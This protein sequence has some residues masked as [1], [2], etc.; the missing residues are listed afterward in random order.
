MR[1]TKAKIEKTVAEAA[2]LIELRQF[3]KALKLLAECTEVDP[4]CAMAHYLTG[5]ALLG[6]RRSKDA[7]KS[8]IR[9]KDLDI[10]P[11]RAT[12]SILEALGRKAGD[13]NSVHT[14]PQRCL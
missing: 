7:L 12:T 13:A 6:L 9:A 1:G 3:Q 10:C 4:L 2:R 8:F 14:F 11:L 5:K